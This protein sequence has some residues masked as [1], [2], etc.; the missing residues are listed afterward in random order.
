MRFLSSKVH[1]IIG[2]IVGIALLFAPELFNLGDSQAASMVP[3][4]VGIFI[5]ISELVTTSPYSLFKLVPMGTHLI[6]DYVTGVFLAVSP[7]LFGFAE[8][9]MRF[10]LPHVAVGVAIILYALV[11]NPA[12]DTDKHLPAM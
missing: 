5:I 10:W 6:I 9:E 11:T 4:L 3:R 2:I 7:W 12:V 8:L 1:T